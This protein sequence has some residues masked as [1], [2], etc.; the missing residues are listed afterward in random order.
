MYS[1]CAKRQRKTGG[2]LKNEEEEE[3]EKMKNLS[4]P[5]TVE[6]HIF[7]TTNAQN[8]CALHWMA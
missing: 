7:Q 2:G 4:W 1:M 5:L 3:E 8:S 6:C